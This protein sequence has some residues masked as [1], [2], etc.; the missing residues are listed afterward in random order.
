METAA[1]LIKRDITPFMVPWSDMFKKFFAASK[2][3]YYQE[4]SRRLVIAKDWDEYFDL[5][6]K[7]TSTGLFADIRTFPWVNRTDRTE[8]FKYWYKSSETIAGDNP[9]SG[10]L[11]NKKWPLKKVL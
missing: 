6:H 1:D 3:P 9:Y 4:I 11:G 7:V 5:V 8:H 10:H 2:D